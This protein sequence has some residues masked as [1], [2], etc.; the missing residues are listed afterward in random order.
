MPSD[1]RGRGQP[2]LRD[3]GNVQRLLLPPHKCGKQARIA[4]VLALLQSKFLLSMI[5]LLAPNPH[6]FLM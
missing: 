6:V 1:T 4:P 3:H 5:C 2:A